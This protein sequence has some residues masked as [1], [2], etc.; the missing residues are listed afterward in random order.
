M[1]D[2]RLM[3]P[4]LLLLILTVGSLS[5]C[6]RTPDLPPAESI[7]LDDLLDGLDALSP[8]DLWKKH[9]GDWCCAPRKP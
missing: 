4:I 3:T 7:T 5:S 6:E 8:E 1:P 9:I 2:K